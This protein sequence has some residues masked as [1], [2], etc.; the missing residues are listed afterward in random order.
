MRPTSIWSCSSPSRGFVSTV[1]QEIENAAPDRLSIHWARR[2]DSWS[3][4]SFSN[5]TGLFS[6][7]PK[8]PSMRSSKDRSSRPRKAC[9]VPLEE[10]LEGDN[11]VSPLSIGHL[12]MRVFRTPSTTHSTVF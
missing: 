4:S 8:K 10:L 5:S 9:R 7:R 1:D 12:E 6:V 11:G 3:S 2:E